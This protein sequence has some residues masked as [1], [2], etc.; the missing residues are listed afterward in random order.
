MKNKEVL[1]PNNETI[2]YFE[3]GDSK[4]TLLLIHGNTS[5]AIFFEPLFEKLPNGL[6]VIA[7]DLRGFGN[8]TYNNN[9]ETL[10]DF[11]DDLKMFLD[12]LGINHVHIVGWSLGGNIAME[13]STN[14][15]NMVNSLVLLSSGSPKGYPVFVK[16]EKG[17]PDF[18]NIYKSK[19]EMALD[20]V[21]VLPLL[22]IYKEKNAQML[23][24]IY[25]VAIYTGK[26]P[27]KDKNLL[28]MQEAIKQRNLV[29]VDWALA[30]FNITNQNSLYSMGNNKISKL[31]AKT[32]IIW[33]NKDLTVPKVMFDETVSLLPEAEVIIYEDCGHSIVVDDP[34]RLAIDILHFI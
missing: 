13:F 27:N 28:W 22:N 34:E 31:K 4:D 5:S 12:V 18:P 29:D 21:Q 7:P 25:D 11:S 15:P 33:G 3:Q 32:L 6:R 10:T 17:Q 20:P 1:L 16:N 9:I 30:N 19:S 24:Y 26:K 8:S 23:A 14:Y 2:H